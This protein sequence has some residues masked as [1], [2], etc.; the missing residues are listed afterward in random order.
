[1]VA[2]HWLT[3]L[4]V[5]GLLATGISHLTWLNP[6]HVME[7]VNQ[8]LSGSSATVSRDV[9]FAFSRATNGAMMQ[10]HFY[11]GFTLTALI[12]IRIILYIRGERR[13]TRL[14]RDLFIPN[15][16][17]RKP[18]INIMYVIA[19]LA[20]LTM[21]T[22]GLLMYFGR[23]LGISRHGHHVIEG[24]HK[25]TMFVILTYVIVHIGGIF[26]AENTKEPGITSS[27]MNG[28]T[29]KEE[30]AEENSLLPQ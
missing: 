15:L 25:T 20:L 27:M 21:I 17:R 30:P 23:D 5:V 14:L 19:Y 7:H 24:I 22:T 13:V 9:M 2:Y 3:A 11:L 29:K 10:V 6:R 4:V 18:L 28:K 12:L 1:M 26:W 16:S 8:L